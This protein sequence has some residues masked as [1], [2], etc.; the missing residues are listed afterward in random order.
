MGFIRF[1]RDSEGVQIWLDNAAEN[2]WV[3]EF[4][5]ESKKFNVWYSTESNACGSRPDMTCESLS[6]VLDFIDGAT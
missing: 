3:F 5:E 2:G 6:K 1:S 4:D